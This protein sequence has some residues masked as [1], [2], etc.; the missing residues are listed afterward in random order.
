M[1]LLE[2]QVHERI[3]KEKDLIKSGINPE[4]IRKNAD[5]MNRPHDLS[6]QG[7]HNP[8]FPEDQPERINEEL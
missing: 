1:E 6:L 5:Q 8:L 7:E 3:I 2:A 4:S